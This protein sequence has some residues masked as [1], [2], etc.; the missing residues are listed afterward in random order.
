VRN[1]ENDYQDQAQPQHV[2]DESEAS[3]YEEE[4][5]REDEQHGNLQLD[6]Q[7]GLGRGTRVARLLATRLASVLPVVSPTETLDVRTT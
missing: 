4:D 6:A 3:E 1:C 7:P 5:D 2:R